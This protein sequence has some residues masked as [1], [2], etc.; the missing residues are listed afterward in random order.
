MCRFLETVRITG[1][2]VENSEGHTER[3]LRTMTS[4][5]GSSVSREARWA[6]NLNGLF[7]PWLEAFGKDPSV[8][9]KGRFLYGRHPEQIS[10]APYRPKTLRTLYTVEPREWPDYCYKLADRHSFEALTAGLEPDADVLI[11]DGRGCITDTSY[12][13]VVFRSGDRYV[14]PATPL[15]AGT[16]RA[17]L[18]AA[19]TI[20][21]RDIF[22]GDIGQFEEIH[23]INALLPLLTV[24]LPVS[25]IKY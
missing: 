9:Y 3:I 6:K 4:W 16:R 21:A 10:C 12:S 1:G 2:R 18:L 25:S 13:N 19:G 11:L 7:A 20:T 23:L 14:T 24:V 22:I 5:Y 8:V 15:L 17:T